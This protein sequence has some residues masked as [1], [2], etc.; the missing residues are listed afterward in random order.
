MDLW[1]LFLTLAF[2][3]PSMSLPSAITGPPEPHRATQAVGTPEIPSSTVKPFAR[4]R[5][6]R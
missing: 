4:S 6:T 1:N 3:I 5:P 2:G